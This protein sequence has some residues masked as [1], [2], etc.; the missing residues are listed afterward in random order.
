MA[1]RVPSCEAE[2]N[3]LHLTQRGAHQ[4]GGLDVAMD[5]APPHPTKSDT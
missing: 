3:D 4:V 5:D 1:F 2:V